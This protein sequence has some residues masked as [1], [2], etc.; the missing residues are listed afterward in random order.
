MKCNTLILHLLKKLLSECMRKIKEDKNNYVSNPAYFTRKRKLPLETLMKL[1]LC[2]TN[3]STNNEI[4]AFFNGEKPQDVPSASALEQQRMKLSPDAF[5]ELFFLFNKGCDGYCNAT[6]KG[7]HLFACDGSD[8]DI[9]LDAADEETYIHEK[10]KGYN[11]IH[12]NALYDLMNNRY[13]D[14]LVQGKQKS[15]ERQSF[16]E[17]VSRSRFGRNVIY[18]CDRGYEGWNQ[19]V[20]VMK[21][22]QSFVIRAKDLE[23]NGVLASLADRLP[24][25]PTFDTVITTTLTKRHTK[26]TLGNPDIYTI[27]SPYTHFDFL[28]DPEACKVTLRVVRFEVSK[29]VYEV[30]I[31][32]LPQN[33]F[34]TADIRTIYMMRWGEE[35]SFRDLKHTIGL[36]YF[37][38]EKR[39]L[40]L[41]EVYSAMT[42]YNFCAIA[43]TE[44]ARY[45]TLKY[46]GSSTKS[47]WVYRI[48]FTTTVRICRDYLQPDIGAEPV[49]SE[50]SIVGMA[51]YVTPIIDGRSFPRKLRPQRFVSFVNRA[52]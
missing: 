27:L 37:H 11:A 2:M 51:R 14:L 19:F 28:D 40:I 9:S 16:N 4:L 49:S 29:G 52:A 18:V 35:N 22:G 38:S 44:A 31:T 23:S 48:N 1:V 42:V 47:K 32:N 33:V 24:K 15:E 45:R 5:R 3:R 13:V 21:M 41:Q 7:Y 46:E 50:D 34:S 17:M 43:H 12:L 20:H 10:E 25:E 39:D 30:V 26:E 8:L 36:I 6:M